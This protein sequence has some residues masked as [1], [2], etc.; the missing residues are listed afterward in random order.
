MNGDG[1][2]LPRLGRSASVLGHV[3]RSIAPVEVRDELEVMARTK[4][5]GMAR[6]GQARP[7]ANRATARQKWKAYNGGAVARGDKRRCA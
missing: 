4:P 2:R 5:A 3:G 1:R 7:R 6:H